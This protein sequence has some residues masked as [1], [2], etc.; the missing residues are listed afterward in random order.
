MAR[1]STAA[2][3]RELL[4]GNELLVAPGVYDGISAALVR[5][6]GLSG[7]CGFDFLLEAGTRAAHL[8]EMNA[9]T[10]PIS[11]LPLAEGRNLV[12]ALATRLDGITAISPM[13]AILLPGE[14][15]WTARPSGCRRTLPGSWEAKPS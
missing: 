2:R 8:I 4:D 14:R 15:R 3:L 9:R 5:K 1:M 6:L 10:T 12:T 11:H 7:F 13:P